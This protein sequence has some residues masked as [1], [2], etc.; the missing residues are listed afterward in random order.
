M[1]L[2][3]Y[4]EKTERKIQRERR[5]I[6]SERETEILRVWKKSKRNT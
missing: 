4:R 6:D 2:K 1:D 3:I 5:H